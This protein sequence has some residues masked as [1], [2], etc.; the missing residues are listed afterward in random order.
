MRYGTGAAL[1][2]AAALLWSLQGLAF[3][4]IEAADPWAILFW[5]SLGMLPVLALFIAVRGRGRLVAAILGAGRDGVIGGL[6]LIFAFGGAVYAIQ[7]TTIANAVFLFA[8]SPFLTALLAWAV[9]GERVPARTWASIGVAALGIAVMVWGGL[10]R[11]AL[12]G[13]LAAL[14][15]AAGFAVFTVTLRRGGIRDPLPGVVLGG[16][17]SMIAAAAMTGLAGG[18]LAVTLPDAGWSLGMGAVTLAGG[19]VL[20]TLGSRAVPA[21]ELTLFTMLEVML[22][23]FWVWLVLGETASRA[24]LAGGLVILAA[25]ALS[26]IRPR[27]GAAVPGA[28][29]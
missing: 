26:A 23:P 3:R 29:A 18:T 24:T 14:S 22:A 28:P 17:F 27:R 25:M 5:R 21:A 2:M 4:Q 15:S 20:Y 12:A 8:A 16:V 9:L 19:M 7:S 6:G 10:D 13:N 1:V 11:G